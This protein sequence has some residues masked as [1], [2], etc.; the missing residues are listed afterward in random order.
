MSSTTNKLKITKGLRTV[1]I[2]ILCMFIGPIVLNSA[3]KNEQHP[4]YYPV[5]II[6]IGI[7]LTAMWLFFKGIKT[8]VSGLF[9]E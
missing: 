7:C 5:M 2:G 3:F 8:M 4:L 9:N 1:A 6:A